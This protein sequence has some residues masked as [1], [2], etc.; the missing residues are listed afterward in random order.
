MLPK[1]A[2]LFS[3]GMQSQ[4]VLPTLKHFPGHG[5]TDMDSH[6]SLPVISHSRSRLD[7]IELYP[8]REGIKNGVAG[9]MTAHLS[10]P[11]LD[12][13]K[14]P[15]S[16]SKQIISKLLIGELGFEGLIVTDAMNM[17]GIANQV[18]DG[19]ADVMAIAAGNDVM[20]FVMDPAKSIASIKQGIENGQISIEDINRKCRKSSNGK[21]AG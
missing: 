16:L 3:L 19:S 1:K 17:Q 10:I 4:N 5:D 12:T 6:L 7:S 2:T 11:A 8:F 18:K 21:N 14:V 13:S 9:I 15:A 20:E